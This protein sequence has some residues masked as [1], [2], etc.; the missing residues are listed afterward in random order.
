MN[1]QLTIRAADGAVSAPTGYVFTK[2]HPA[3]DTKFH[4]ITPV[5]AA[6]ETGTFANTTE[7]SAEIIPQGYLIEG[8]FSTVRIH[9]GLVRAY[10]EK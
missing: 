6:S 7:A 4:T 10:C 3:H 1:K 5:V 2:L 8:R 9:S